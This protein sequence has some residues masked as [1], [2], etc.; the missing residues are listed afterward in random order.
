MPD[1]FDRRTIL[2][3]A[4]TA[5]AA[6]GPASALAQTPT[7]RQEPAPAPAPSNGP[8]K[9]GG[10]A[11]QFGPEQ[12]FSFDWL[13][14]RAKTMAGQPYQ[15]PPRPAPEVLDQITYEEWGKIKFDM[16]S[17][18]YAQGTAAG[19]RFPISFFHLGKF[20]QKAIKVYAVDGASARELLYSADYFD[21]PV[22]SVARKLPAGAGYAGIR[23]QESKDGPL[24]W[25]KND[26]VAFLGAS[27]FRAIGELRQYG[28]SARG[29]ALDT[30]QAGRDEEFPDFTQFWIGPEQGDS[31]TLHALL[32]GPGIVG[33]YKFVMMRGAGV[34][35]DID[36]SLH[37]RKEYLR[38]GLA[39]LTSMYWFSETRKPE[40]VD[41]RPE[42]HDSDG[43]AMWT[44]AGERLW[45]PLNNPPR[46]TASAFGDENPRGFGLLQRDRV[47]DHYE[48]GVYYD[49]RPSVWI[50]PKG[51]W[52][53]GTVQLVEIPTDDEIH[54]NIVAMWVPAEA[55]KPGSEFDLSYRV[56]WLAD[57]PHPTALARCVATRLGNGGV[58]GLPRPKGVRKFMVEFQGGEL[59]TLPKGVNPECVLWASRGTFSYIYTEAVPDDVPG[60]WRAQFD[61]TADG[62]DPVEMRLALKVGDKV[63]SENWLFQYQPF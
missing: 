36:C 35:M 5:A 12:P 3:T 25:H 24:D 60:H 61:L 56:Y 55:A 38:F 59:A 46:V 47:F 58:P 28:L 17:A 23:I 57:E 29:I 13:K 37:L 21:M 10:A 16:N 43:L 33:A 32:E 54:D 9:A 15:G 6:L 26:W 41:W 8:T 45:R 62:K 42:V 19:A 48:D 11:L 52:G 1:P 22:D 39:P 18:L 7:Q 4:A 20:F 31:V 49:R 30:W 34:I 51:Q 63:V 14:G 53:K 40:A 50:E 27:Y 2:K 44:G